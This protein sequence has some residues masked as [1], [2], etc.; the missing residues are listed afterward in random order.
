ML[1]PFIDGEVRYSVRNEYAQTAAD[2]LARRTRLA[3]LN[4]Q[5]ALEALP[6]VIDIM[7]EEL[8]WD[9][10]RKDLEWRETVAF[11]ASMGLPKSKL[12]ATRKDV[13][14][15]KMATYEASEYELYSRH[16]KFLHDCHSE[17]VY[18]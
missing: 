1:Y 11:L 6:T 4:A 5:A 14:S 10:K 17:R 15:G 8:K 3:F 18:S 9:T 2:V 12:T 13:E 16:G 7:G